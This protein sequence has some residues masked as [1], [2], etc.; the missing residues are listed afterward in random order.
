M[1]NWESELIEKKQIFSTNE[2]SELTSE[3]QCTFSNIYNKFWF[4]YTKKWELEKSNK[5]IEQQRDVLKK[6]KRK[7]DIGL[8]IFIV[9][10]AFIGYVRDASDFERS[11]VMISVVFYYFWNINL[12]FGEDKIHH[13]SILLNKQT[14]DLLNVNNSNLKLYLVPEAYQYM[15]IYDKYE[16]NFTEELNEDEQLV[17]K[18]FNVELDL[19]IMQSLGVKIPGFWS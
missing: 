15:S 13:T 7:A 19:A 10:I 9:V 18:T 3:Q 2:F 17:V 6:T 14:I 16:G 4:V 12:I 8:L 11:L 1:K 5:S